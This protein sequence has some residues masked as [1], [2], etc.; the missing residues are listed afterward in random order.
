MPQESNTFYLI[1]TTLTSL[2]TLYQGSHSK[3]KTK[4]HDFSM[5]PGYFSMLLN[6]VLASCVIC[7]NCYYSPKLFLSEKIWAQVATSSQTLG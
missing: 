7:L 5:I 1:F 6:Y 2:H 3:L 4:F